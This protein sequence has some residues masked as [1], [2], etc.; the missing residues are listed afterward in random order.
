MSH[1]KTFDYLEQYKNLKGEVLTAVERVLSSGQLILGQEVRCFEKT[2]AEFLGGEGDCVGVN[3]GTDALIVALKVLEVGPGDEVITVA[4]TAVATVSAIRAVGA[5]PVFCDVDLST[6]LMDLQELPIRI[7][8]NTKAVIPV[9][10]FGNVVNVPRI[11]E[12][13]GDRNIKI[14][15]D[16]AQAHGAKF[17]D[18]MAGT[19]GDIGAF[20]F[21]PTKN[22]GAYG[23][24]GAC[25]ST[26]SMLTGEM[27]KIRMYGFE[28][29]YDSTREGMNSRLD[30]LQ[31]AILKVKMKYLPNYLERR[32]AIAEHYCRKLT[33]KAEHVLPGDEVHHA[34]HLFVIKVP[35]RNK[36]QEELRQRGVDTGIHYPYPIHLMQSYRFLGYSQ[37]SLPRTETLAEQILSLPLYP[38]LSEESIN[39]V[40]DELNDILSRIK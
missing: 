16:C 20:S 23:D 6:S 36:V 12:I 19:M 40:C 13:I 15:E 34:Y 31:A 4:N 2:F 26:D 32:R 18:R 39:Q 27:R 35:E 24:G 25:Y 21:Y 10:L 22:L 17:R 29:S 37:G 38:E 28:G 8:N 5:I 11:Q 9:H 33:P 3:S 14:I 30:E 7:T 1:V